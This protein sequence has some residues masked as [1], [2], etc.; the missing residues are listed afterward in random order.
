MRGLL[1]LA[2]TLSACSGPRALLRKAEGY[3]DAERYPAAVRTY[4][5]VLEKKPGE[6]R[7]LVG[8]ARAWLM[9]DEPERAIVPAQV[10]AET[11]VPGGE[12]VLIDALLVNGRGADA[13][14]RAERRGGSEGKASTDDLRR[15]AE[16][17]LAAGNVSAAVG[18]AEKM[19]EAGGGADAMALAAWLHARA[20]SCERAISLAGRA[21]TGA[22][23]SAAIQAEAA[24]VF[25]HCGDGP[26]AQASAST[27]LTLLPQGPLAWER[28]AARRQK[29]GD[30][31]GAA[32]E[33][34]RLRAL[35]PDDGR[36]A[37]QL[38]GLW[39]ARE[40]WG[41]A[42]NELAAAL[43]LPPYADASGQGGV[44]FAE[45]QADALDPEAR[46]EAA[47]RI[48]E[49]L[50]V[51]RS[52]RQD[53]AGVAEALTALAELRGARSA[54]E[55]LRVAQAWAETSTPERG[56]AAAQRVLDQAPD[57]FEAHAFIARTLVRSG[58]V[59]RAIGHARAAFA[60]RPDDPDAALLLA[61]L[62][63]ARGESREAVETLRGALLS[64][65]KD[66]RLQEAL[67][68]HQQGGP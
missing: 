66:R 37:R 15:L 8:V 53:R 51:A 21:V 33:L 23:Q 32:R 52:K 11:K 48:W 68:K 24:A 2:V 26:R 28:A 13:L 5:R 10:A 30:H 19:V 12:E 40:Q 57:S 67:R 61:S 41:R 31:E 55:W 64:H 29:G 20:D 50:A 38:G 36:Y 49:D 7:A 27:A 60:V 6:P 63:G 42:E 1:L 65:P 56:L 35:V 43:Q 18:A 62:Y 34:S 39:L 4:E 25:R 44:R 14:A 47:V 54:A 16:A 9:T 58:A 46:V 59:D 22:M 17:R 45:R 3:M